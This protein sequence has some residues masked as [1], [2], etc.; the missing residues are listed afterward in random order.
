MFTIQHADIMYSMFNTLLISSFIM[1]I[2][3]LGIGVRVFPKVLRLPK[4]IILP[5]VLIMALAGSYNTSTSVKDVWVSVLMG[6]AGYFFNKFDFPKIPVIITMVLGSNFEQ[7]LRMAL[8]N[9]DG[10]FIPMFTRPYSLLFVLIILFT[11]VLAV[12]RPARMRRAEAKLEL[13]RQT[14]KIRGQ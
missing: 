3:M 6:F 2:L 10:T 11:I 5:V 9:Y 12:T 1:L 4:Q 7:Q 8:K 13:K 14:A